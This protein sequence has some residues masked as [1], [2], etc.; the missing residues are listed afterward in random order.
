MLSFQI[1]RQRLVWGRGLDRD[2]VLRAQAVGG[3]RPRG[4]SELT[5]GNHHAAPTLLE[6]ATWGQQRAEEVR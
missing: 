5:L 3:V 1:I 2:W 6:K 4:A